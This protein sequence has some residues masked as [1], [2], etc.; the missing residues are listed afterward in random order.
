MN[1]FGREVAS[2]TIATI[3]AGIV[4]A[5]L[6]AAYKLA[7]ALSTRFGITRETFAWPIA[8]VAV[9]ALAVVVWLWRR[10]PAPR[11]AKPGSLVLTLNHGTKPCVTL[12]HHG[13]ATTYR[14]DGR[15]VSHVDGTQSPQPAQFRCQLQRGGIRDGWDVVLQDGDWANIILGSIE[16]VLPASS[17]GLTPAQSW[18]P[19]GKMLVIRRGQMGQHVRVPDSGAIVELTIKATPPLAEPI[20]PRLFQVVRSGGDIDQV[21]SSEGHEQSPYHCVR[22][23]SERK[24]PVI[25]HMPIEDSN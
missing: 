8:A 9:I 19:V 10:K 11:P 13:G 25:R 24:V 3:L 5:A 7:P 23:S 14:A 22:W 18:T 12:T 16:D 20:G 17:K 2:R 1:A 15:I 21:V 6:G 4:L